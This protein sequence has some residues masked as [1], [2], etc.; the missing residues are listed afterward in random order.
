MMLDGEGYP[1]VEDDLNNPGISDDDQAS[2]ELNS[3]QET[4]MA[5]VMMVRIA[6]FFHLLI[7]L[8]LFNG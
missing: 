4:D 7:Y 8:S 3:D 6:L 5:S 2:L 1:N